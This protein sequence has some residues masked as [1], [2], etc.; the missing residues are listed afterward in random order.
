MNQIEY[1]LR[2]QK[3]WLLAE[4]G[5][6]FIGVPAVIAAGWFPVL[7]IP[8][9]LMM[10]V[11][12]GLTLRWGYHLRLADL[13]RVRLPV[14][15]WLRIL[16]IFVVAL[17]CMMEF[18]WLIKPEALFGLVQNHP[19]IWLLVMIAYP[20]LSVLPQELIYRAFFF[21]RYRPIFGGGYGMLLGSAAVFSFGHIIFHN[22]PSVLLTFI[23]GL[24]FGRTYQRTTSLV[25]VSV[26]HALYGCAVFT[27]GY[28]QYFLDGTLRLFHQ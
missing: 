23:G 28:G 10:A 16:A 11:G 9:L 3:L 20:V 6:L 24:L 19:K 27:L 5:A 2:H 21:E 12:C 7:V 4:F 14:W 1:S 15:E 13:L 17:P 22:W 18:L 25:L 26:E 8:V